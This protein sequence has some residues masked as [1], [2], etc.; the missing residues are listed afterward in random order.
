MRC[1][2]KIIKL[3][4]EIVLYGDS[5]PTISD[6][7]K[8]YGK[9]HPKSQKLY[10]RALKVLPSGVSHD[11]RIARP[12]PVYMTRAEGAYKWDVDGN[13]Y[14]DYVMGHGGTLFGYGDKRLRAALE[15]ALAAPH[16][17]ACT[18][19][20]IEWAETITRLVP[21]GKN[22]YVRGCS[23]GGEAVEEAVRLA[24]IHTGNDKIVI[25]E[26]CYH[27]KWEET[28]V[29]RGPPY[30]IVNQKGIPKY[31]RDNVILVPY[32]KPEAAEA[33]FKTGEIACILLQG[34]A[35][36]TKDYIKT[37]RELTTKYGVVFLMDEVVSGF[38]YAVEGAQGYY[39]VT[40][41]L[42][43]LGK[44]V[45]GGAP[46]GAVTGPKEFM[47][48]LEFRDSN[49][50]RFTRS[51]TG[52]TWNSQPLSISAG[53]VA[54]DICDKEREKIY[55][56]LYEI[57]KKLVKAIDDAAKDYR[58]KITGTGLPPDNPT[59]VAARLDP[60]ASPLA[61]S[62]IYLSMVNNGVFSYGGMPSNTCI[63]YSDEDLKKTEEAIDK[64]FAVLKENKLVPQ[65]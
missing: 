8:E 27:G 2:G 49:W 29:G 43:T 55:P 58:L 57:G 3:T 11:G 23:C 39:G 33:A 16:M 6:L 4:T 64:T 34:N 21:C 37:L 10:E 12:F 18:E 20:E 46:C 9:K 44:I 15:N 25:H 26:G 50:N 14:V 1:L 5:L 41:D 24:R 52:G 17:G 47:Q 62:A 65:A 42:T 48:Y 63:K 59:Q 35:P 22:G 32:N 38:R 30:G 61:A 28:C 31:I 13:Q 40:P 45:G 51:A 60:G 54:M 19:A 56:R 36:Y 7:E 53:I